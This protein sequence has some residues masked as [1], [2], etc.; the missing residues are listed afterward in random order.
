MVSG[1]DYVDTTS[2]KN[3]YAR[4]PEKT[5]RFIQKVKPNYMYLLQDD[6]TDDTTGYTTTGA[7]SSSKKGVRTTTVSSDYGM[8]IV[9][10]HVKRV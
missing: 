4:N 5:T 7:S 8:E 9:V 10:K 2:V 6:S 3:I 1:Q